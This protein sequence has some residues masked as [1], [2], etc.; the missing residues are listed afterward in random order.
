MGLRGAVV[1]VPMCCALWLKGRVNK[2]WALIAIIAGPVFVLIFGT[3]LKLPGGIDSLFAGV[4]AALVC[5][6][7]G[8]IVGNKEPKEKLG[9]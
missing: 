1:F 3:V 5:C 7:I 9:A 4:A 6:I 8:L 2:I